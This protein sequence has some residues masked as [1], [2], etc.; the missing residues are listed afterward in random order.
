MNGKLL[1]KKTP[2]FLSSKLCTRIETYWLQLIGE[3]LRPGLGI[4]S[5]FASILSKYTF[6]GLFLVFGSA[7][8]AF[9]LDL[10]EDSNQQALRYFSDMDTSNDAL[11]DAQELKLWL[12]ARFQFLDTNGD[13]FLNSQEFSALPSYLLQVEGILGTV[14]RR[15]YQVSKDADLQLWDQNHDHKLSLFEFM[16]GWK[17]LIQ[18]LDKNHDGALDEAEFVSTDAW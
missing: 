7:H 8:Q 14:A 2:T 10:Q 11:A 15:R 18:V 17:Q 4:I 13:D 12:E 9:A 3:Y 1:D 5:F 16:D 6:L